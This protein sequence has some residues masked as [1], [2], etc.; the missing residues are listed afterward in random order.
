M[1][2]ITLPSNSSMKYFPNN[3]LTHFTTQL[4]Q[5]IQLK[6]EWE[7]GLVEIQYPRSWYNVREGKVW[8][9]LSHIDR[10][11]DGGART[12]RLVLPEGYYPTPTSLIRGLEKLLKETRHSQVRPL[13]KALSISFDENTRKYLVALTMEKTVVTFSDQLKRMLGLRY[14]MI[15]G[16]ANMIGVGDE[17][18]HADIPTLYVYSDLVEPRVVGDVRAPLL[19]II[20][21]RGSYGDHVDQT[22]Q[23]VEYLPCRKKDFSTIEIDIRDDTGEPVPFERGKLVVTLHFRQTR[24]LPWQ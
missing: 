24:A 3:T 2:Y 14:S 23:H 7:V 19:R 17:D 10:P 20:P 22:F 15:T 1:F 21:S 9:T 13:S 8:L 12:H 6:G 16:P 4:P 18:I 5:P 11:D